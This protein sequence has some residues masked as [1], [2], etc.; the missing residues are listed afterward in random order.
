M[1]GLRFVGADVMEVCPPYDLAGVT[2]LAG[3]QVGLELLG[4]LGQWQS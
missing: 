2:A 3:A 4:L 1:A